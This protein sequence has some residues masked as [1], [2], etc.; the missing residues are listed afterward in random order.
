MIVSDLLANAYLIGT[1]KTSKMA[2]GDKNWTTLL[3]YANI[4]LQ[5]WASEPGAEWASLYKQVDCGT[6]TNT[7]AYDL[8][9]SIRALSTKPGDPIQIVTTDGAIY[10][11]DLVKPDELQMSGDRVCARI[12]N[13][14]VFNREFDSSDTEFG[15]TLLVSAYLYPATLEN[16]NDTVQIDDPNWL[17][18]MVAAMRVQNDSVLAYNYPNLVSVANNIMTNMKLAN[19]GQQSTIPMRPAT[20]RLRL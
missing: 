19:M 10:H 6:I 9:D 16:E 8:D 7:S 4:A 18:Y 17:V 20:P 2:V 11:F 13:Q 14:I 1:G 15:G 12:G 5:T 3:Q